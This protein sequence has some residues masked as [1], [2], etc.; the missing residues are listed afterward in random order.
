MTSLTLAV[1]DRTPGSAISI[2]LDGTSFV[3]RPADTKV[4]HQAALRTQTSWTYLALLD[5]TEKGFDADIL[6]ALVFLARLQAG[7]DD[8]LFTEVVELLDATRTATV[9]IEVAETALD[10]ADSPEA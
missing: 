8:V 1:L 3:F 5:A 4:A 6:S 7:D 10:E 9:S 2:D